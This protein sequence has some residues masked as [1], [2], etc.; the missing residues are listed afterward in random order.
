MSAQEA[1]E[2]GLWLHGEAA[3]LAGPAFIADDLASKLPDAI[4]RCQ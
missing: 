1:A 3:R 4:A 2:A